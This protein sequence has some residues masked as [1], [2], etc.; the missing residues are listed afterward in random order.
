MWLRSL[1][2]SSTHSHPPTDQTASCPPTHLYTLTSTNRP[3]RQS[4]TH[5]L[6][7]QHAT[8]SIIHPLAHPS[9]A[10]TTR[11]SPTHPPTH[12][13]A[14]P[15]THRCAMHS[16]VDFEP[17]FHFLLCDCRVQL[18]CS[19]VWQPQDKVLFFFLAAPFLL[20]TITH[21]ACRGACVKMR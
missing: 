16:H 8:P 3:N 17:V 4:S 1:V 20:A 10:H 19:R 12:P 15:P 21:D 11:R 9:T 5:S 6:S 14:R 13:P 2:S 18:C 7:V